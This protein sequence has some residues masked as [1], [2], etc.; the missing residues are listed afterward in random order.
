MMLSRCCSRPAFVCSSCCCLNCIAACGSTCANASSAR[1]FVGSRTKAASAP[2]AMFCWRCCW[3]FSMPCWIIP[4]TLGAI[5]RL[6]SNTL[7]LL[8]GLLANLGLE[9]LDFGFQRFDVGGEAGPSFAG[10]ELAFG[11]L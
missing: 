11:G 6:G 10:G 7:R 4:P 5:I 9:L 2:F 8:T 1:W 3:P